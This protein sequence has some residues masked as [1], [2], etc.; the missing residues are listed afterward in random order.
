VLTLAQLHAF[1]LARADLLG[2][3]PLSPERLLELAAH[4]EALADA[5]DDWVDRLVA[6]ADAAPAPTSSRQ[7]GAS[8]VL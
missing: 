4:M 8:R 7:T 1:E 5:G 2:E 6:Q 3:R